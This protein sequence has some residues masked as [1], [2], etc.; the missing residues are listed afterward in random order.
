MGGPGFALQADPSRGHLSVAI[1]TCVTCASG[2]EVVPSD[3]HRAP[4]CV[5]RTRGAVATGSLH[6]GHYSGARQGIEQAGGGIQ[7][8]LLAKVP[9]SHAVQLGALDRE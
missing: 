7:P 9:G 5:G 3:A 2:V 4:S 6:G 8:L 1:R